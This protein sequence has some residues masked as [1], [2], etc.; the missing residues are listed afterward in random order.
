MSSETSVKFADDPFWTEDVNVLIKKDRLIE[1]V[2]TKDMSKDERLNALAR[3]SVYIGIVL[4]LYLAKSWPLYIPIVG[5]AFTI[6]LNKTQPEAKIPP[7]YPTNETP[8]QD[9]PNPFIPSEQPVCIPPTLNNPFMNVLLNEYV[10]NP[11]RPA[12]CEYETVKDELESN[13]HYNLYQDLGDNIWNKNNSQREFFTMPYTTIP[14]NQGDFARWLYKTGPTCKEDG[15]S[16]Y[17]YEDLRSNRGVVGDS[18]YL[19]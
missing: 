6:F 4:M 1:F 5:L 10:D 7:K 18:E 9:D 13:F 12:A 11:T 14:N 19:M 8:K 16:C 15:A 3:L 2:P 17:R